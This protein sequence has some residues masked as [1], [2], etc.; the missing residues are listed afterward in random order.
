[1]NY[2]NKTTLVSCIACALTLPAIATADDHM[3]KASNILY[4]DISNGLNTFGRVDNVLLD[5]NGDSVEYLFFEK[6]DS[7]R[8]ASSGKGFVE[9]SNV[10]FNPASAGE[11]QVLVKD[12]DAQRKPQE[13]K[14]SYSEAESRLLSRVLD[15]SIKFSDQEIRRIDDILI[16]RDT[17]SIKYF[18]VD[19]ATDSFFSDD[20][21]AIP[22]DEVNITW[23]GTVTSSASIADISRHR[24]YQMDSL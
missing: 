12:T 13:L 18:T 20:V 10:D 2:L 11:V 5:K 22:A 8:P 24:K 15:K 3:I 4:S 9:M 17:G 7:F 21:R 6:S 1:M 23:S 19:M 14:V 16:D